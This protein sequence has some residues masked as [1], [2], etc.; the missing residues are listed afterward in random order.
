MSGTTF[1]GINFSSYKEFLPCDFLVSTF[2]FF[3][4]L[5]DFFLLSSVWRSYP[6]A[7]AV[8]SI[9]DVDGVLQNFFTLLLDESDL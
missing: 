4:A 8:V 9:L 5:L 6:K 3:V 1:S 7:Y 2:C